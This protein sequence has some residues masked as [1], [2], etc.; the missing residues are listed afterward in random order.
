M[1]I[2]ELHLS[3]FKQY[4][5]KNLFDYRKMADEIVGYVTYMGYTHIE[6]MPISEYPFDGSWG[7]QKLLD[8]M[9]QPLVLEHL[10]ILCILLIHVIKLV[11]VLS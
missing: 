2:Y 5:D 3:S 7:Y 8:I 6:I 4:Q 1:N 9:L 10:L 11:L